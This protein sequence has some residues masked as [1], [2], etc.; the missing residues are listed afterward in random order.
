MCSFNI[1]WATTTAYFNQEQSL[2]PG[3]IWAMSG[4]IFDWHNLGRWVLLPSSRGGQGCCH[5]LQCTGEPLSPGQRIL[6][7]MVEKFC[8]NV[9]NTGDAKMNKSLPSRGSQLRYN[10]EIISI[11]LNWHRTIVAISTSS[12]YRMCEGH[13]PLPAVHHFLL[14]PLEMIL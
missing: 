3:L 13:L 4:D 1:C 7:P 5:I 11:L 2:P 6:H 8:Y 14:L 9:P 12:K 10:F